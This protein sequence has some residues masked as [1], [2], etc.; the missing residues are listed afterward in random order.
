MFLKIIWYNLSCLLNIILYHF[1]K[2]YQAQILH[3]LK[4]LLYI[5]P[6]LISSLFF[7]SESLNVETGFQL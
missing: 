3:I 6:V 1:K 4:Y 7:A 5:F 2:M